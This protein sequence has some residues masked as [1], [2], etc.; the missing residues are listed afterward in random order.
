VKKKY[1][2]L[3]L[4]EREEI[5]LLFAQGFSLGDIARQIDRDKSTISRE[6]TRNGPS[7]NK[8]YYRAHKAQE[9]AVIRNAESH[10]RPRLKDD[11]I[12]QYVIKKLAEGL[13]PE[14]I[15]GRL[16]KEFSEKTVSYESIYQ[17]I[18][19]ENPDLIKF[20]TRKHKRRKSKGQS[21]KHLKSHIAQRISIAKRSSKIN[22]RKRF[23][24]WEADTIVSRESKAA[25]CALIERK[26]R[27]LILEKLN[28]KTAENMKTALVSALITLPKKLRRTITYDNGS[29]NTKHMIANQQLGTKSYFCAPYHSWEKGSVENAIGIVRRYFPKKT[30][31]SKVSEQDL[32]VVENRINNRPKKCLNYFTPNEVFARCCT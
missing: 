14:L 3:N 15:S 12:K 25:V 22:K 11:E 30:D 29:E 23:G 7:L 18:Y 13:S 28:R 21:K 6:I 31:F 2:H 32:K 10:A 5:S 16:N 27:K 20:L 26:S 1:T 8:G 9:R 4:E 24:D 19:L 17:Y